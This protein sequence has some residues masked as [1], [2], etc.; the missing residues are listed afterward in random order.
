MHAF[1]LLQTSTSAGPAVLTVQGAGV[2]GQAVGLT[3]RTP[4]PWA[5]ASTWKIQASFV[6]SALS[7]QLVL[8]ATSAGA[9]TLAAFD[10]TDFSQ[11]WLLADG[12]RG[13][14]TLQ[15]QAL[16]QLLTASSDGTSV[17]LGPAASSGDPPPQQLWSRYADAST[18]EV[19]VH[20]AS[21]AALMLVPSMLTGALASPDPVA[22]PPGCA[23][24]VFPQYQDGLAVRVAI[25]TEGDADVV[26]PVAT[27]TATQ[28]LRLRSTAPATVHVR[29]ITTLMGWELD[30]PTIH[31]PAH[32][33]APGRLVVRIRKG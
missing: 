11:A 3:P 16:N 5:P 33:D 30:G 13:S 21:N 2:P 6:V 20:N 10:P 7:P 24:A 29:G 9:V 28:T 26:E 22:I 15:N 4:G 12:Q 31:D 23:A 18:L 19:V 14:F 1:H 17:G 32:L 27:F 25:C 8:A